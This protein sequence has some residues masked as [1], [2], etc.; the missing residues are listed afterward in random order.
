MIFSFLS[1]LESPLEI[2][3]LATEESKSTKTDISII[4]KLVCIWRD[5]KNL[6]YT[7]DLNF[8]YE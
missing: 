2:F 5:H 4:V 7:N 8:E 3:F 1:S 6:N